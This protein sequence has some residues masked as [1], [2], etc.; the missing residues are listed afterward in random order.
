[1]QD[2]LVSPTVCMQECREALVLEF[3][4]HPLLNMEDSISG[5]E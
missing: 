2:M 4:F 5:Y 3:T 1:M